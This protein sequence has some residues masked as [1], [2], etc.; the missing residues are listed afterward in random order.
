MDDAGDADHA[1]GTPKVAAP[2]MVVVSVLFLLDRHDRDGRHV[3]T[4][5]IRSK[6][7]GETREYD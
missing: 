6:V 4:D 1:G 3:Y 2:Q 7:T 5:A